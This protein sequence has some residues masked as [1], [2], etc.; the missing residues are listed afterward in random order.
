MKKH[1]KW[2]LILLVFLLV[3]LVTTGFGVTYAYYRTTVT[4]AVSNKTSDYTGE[5]QV[6]SGTH[7]L[8]PV[9]SSPVDTIDFYIKNYTGTDS[10]NPTNS[11]EVYLSYTLTFSITGNWGSGCT[12][13]VSYR[14]FAVND[15]NNT[16]TEVT[17]TNNQT[18][19]IDFSLISAEK[20]HYK[21]KLYWDMSNNGATCYAGK[22][23][24]VG[25]AT[26]M[27]QTP[28]KYTL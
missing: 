18:G 24:S 2:L 17:L 22:S 8:V 10:N 6:T 21:L 20:D 26:N 27:Y 11:S 25:I 9:A 5:I 13:P 4:G 19:A 12:N 7:V 14:L 16:E 28:S 23:G 15:S 3:S 1:Y